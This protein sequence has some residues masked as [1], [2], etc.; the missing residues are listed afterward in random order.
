MSDHSAT[1][2]DS[3]EPLEKTSVIAPSSISVPVE[4]S[5]AKPG[6]GIPQITRISP[7]APETLT[8]AP[9]HLHNLGAGLGHVITITDE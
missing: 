4:G 1:R 9:N 3:C 7:L 5:S 2:I 6:L 8:R